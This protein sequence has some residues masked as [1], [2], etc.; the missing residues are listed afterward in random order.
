MPVDT[1]ERP[2]E[3]LGFKLGDREYAIDI[4]VIEIIVETAE[5]AKVP[6]SQNFLKGVMNLRGRIVPVVDMK[7]ITLAN[8][9]QHS[10]SNVIVT[11][12]DENEIGFLVDN[13]TEVMWI[14]PNEFDPSMKI[15]GSNY[16]KGVIIKANRL[17]SMLDL[18][19]FVK[20]RMSSSI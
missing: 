3:V 5:I 15:E 18:Q 17:L 19:S 7:R 8:D 11:M 16:V 6:N 10:G 2:F 20:D 12:I 4:G 1:L 13:V 14:Q 9:S